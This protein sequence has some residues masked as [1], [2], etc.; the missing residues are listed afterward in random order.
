MRVVILAALL[1]LPATAFA[2]MCPPGQ[3]PGM[4]MF[5][6][7]TCQRVNGGGTASVFGG[8]GGGCPN[9]SIPAVD[10]YGNRVCQN[11]A[12]GQRL[13]DTSQGCPNGTIPWVDMYGN[14]VCKRP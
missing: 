4:D 3:I 9:G 12:N 1:L 2:Q 14:H 13:Y 10:S 6:N 8:N 11:V 7:R 5:G